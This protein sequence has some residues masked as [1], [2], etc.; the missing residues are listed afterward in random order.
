MVS[1]QAADLA[2]FFS[3]IPLTL[4]VMR[5]VQEEM[6][7]ASRQEHLAE[8]F[9]GGIVERVTAAS[10][11]CSPDAIVYDFCEGVRPL[12]Q[13]SLRRGEVIDVLGVVSRFVER[14]FG[15]ALDFG[16]LIEDPAG[17][18]ALP[19]DLQPFARIGAELLARVLPSSARARQRRR[20]PQK[21]Q[22]PLIN[23]PPPP[24]M[25]VGRKIALKQAVGALLAP[26]PRRSFVT[27]MGAARRGDHFAPAIVTLLGADGIGKFTLARAIAHESRVR[28]R[29]PDGIL[30]LGEDGSGYP[31]QWLRD[32]AAAIG[33]PPPF[34]E[35]DIVEREQFRALF[36]DRRALFIAD[37]R[38]ASD[39]L[40]TLIEHAGRRCTVLRLVS[41][42]PSS[43]SLTEPS[44]ATIERQE[45]QFIPLGPLDDGAIA[46]IGQGRE[47]AFA[48]EVESNGNPLIARMI[49]GLAQVAPPLSFP[50]SHIVGGS[51]ESK[52]CKVLWGHLTPELRAGLARLLN[53]ARRRTLLEKASFGR[54]WR[55]P[56]G[57][58]DQLLK[59][60]LLEDLGDR[61]RLHPLVRSALFD[62]TRDE[63]D[64][65][66][67]REPVYLC[68]AEDDSRFGW[69]LWD[70]LVTRGIPVVN[71]ARDWA[72]SG[73]VLQE[74][75]NSL[76]SVKAV[77]V[78]L[79]EAA[80]DAEWIMRLADEARRLE[81]TPLC[82][83]PQPA[84]ERLTEAASSLGHWAPAWDEETYAE[85]L[86]GVLRALPP[87]EVA[88]VPG[89]PLQA[90]VA[91]IRDVDAPWCPELVTLPAGAFVM[92]S[93]DTEKE[94]FD[95]EGPQHT[96][97]IGN[98]FAIGRYAVTFEEYDA[99]CEATG[100]E[101]P[102]D[103]GWGRGRRP[104]INVS[105]RDARA[106]CEWLSKETGF[107]YR[108]P[109]E[110]EWE[111]A[112]RA[113]TT[114]RFAFGDEITEEAANFG[115]KVGRTADV[116]AYPPN[117]WGLC[118]MHGNVW[119]FV[120]DVWQHSYEGAPDD[121][122]AWIDVEGEQSS[123][124]RVVR[125]GSWLNYPGGCRSACRNRVVPN[126]RSFIGG[127]RVARRVS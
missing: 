126:D 26:R 108:L 77:I 32:Y 56:G 38:A 51:A 86:D 107:P 89:D 117:A 42:A 9:V 47:K 64:S 10:E 119:E 46:A 122:A 125:G 27:Q 97:T 121:G 52:I 109:S 45:V 59:A 2:A 68:Y 76:P 50:P 73:A 94:R 103:Q 31:R 23:L 78:V 33:V 90:G 3:A 111:Y 95:D 118:E 19:A 87:H 93:P 29:Y 5:I 88:F 67:A 85:T 63:G 43:V 81:M 37:H 36:A 110:A 55:E 41:H 58:I 8:V 7:P 70:D 91:V 25:L 74:R 92:G 105:W 53:L 39:M 106:Y 104:V 60:A 114:T 102:D 1:P 49:Y 75:I 99:F 69:R 96:V 11:R 44:T 98:R 34:G 18:L 80:L 66:A 16:A 124:H 120:E 12:L 4:P 48:P 65:Q 61:V 82:V 127:F 113:G 6:A 54:R 79:S 123:R 57:L 115:S 71:L 101:T 112:C 28:D 21:R 84:S 62:L 35:R 40:P 17:A 13:R 100:H 72:P 22:P 83:L 15:H 20:S 14:R 24:E 116:G 30:W